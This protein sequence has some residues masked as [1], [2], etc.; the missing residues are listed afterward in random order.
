MTVIVLFNCQLFW[1]FTLFN[2]T[3]STEALLT[4]LPLLIAEF[5]FGILKMKHDY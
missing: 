5:G 1:F 2:R 4:L 3:F